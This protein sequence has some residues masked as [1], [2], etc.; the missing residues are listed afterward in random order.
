MLPSETPLDSI[1][2]QHRELYGHSTSISLT[3][4][5]CQWALF[6]HS[7]HVRVFVIGSFRLEYSI[8]AK[9]MALIHPARENKWPWMHHLSPNLIDMLFFSH[10]LNIWILKLCNHATFKMTLTR[11][12][13]ATS[14]TAASC[15]VASVSWWRDDGLTNVWWNR[16][17]NSCFRAFAGWNDLIWNAHVAFNMRTLKHKPVMELDCDVCM[18]VTGTAVVVFLKLEAQYVLE[19][20]V[21]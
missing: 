11:L 1:F 16:C 14:W 3:P 7:S 15:S 9:C 19:L 20:S 18:S 4:F 17:V 13:I 8:C 10:Y 2:K 21:K 5:C 6:I 12:P